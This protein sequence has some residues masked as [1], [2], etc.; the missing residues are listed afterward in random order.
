MKWRG[1]MEIYLSGVKQGE[2][3]VTTTKSHTWGS[4]RE[5][6]HWKKI[7]LLSLRPKLQIFYV[8]SLTNSVIIMHIP[9]KPAMTFSVTERSMPG[10]LP[11]RQEDSSV[12]WVIACFWLHLLLSLSQNNPCGCWY[13]AGSARCWSKQARTE[14]IWL[15]TTFGQKVMFSI[16]RWLIF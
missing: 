9:P 11:A 7:A 2:N 5:S 12:Q 16:R 3:R 8:S 15:T 14:W 1:K 6:Q 10:P 4:L 13:H